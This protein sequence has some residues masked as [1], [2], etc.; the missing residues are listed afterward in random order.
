MTVQ[1]DPNFIEYIG[2]GAQLTFAF[3]FRVD[4]VAWVSLS[5]VL[6]LLDITLNVD[7]DLNPGGVVSYNIAPPNL[8]SIRILRITPNNQELN[9]T[10]YDPFDSESHESALDRLTMQIQ[11]AGQ[12]FVDLVAPGTVANSSLRYDPTTPPGY[13]EFGPGVDEYFF[14]A[15]DGL[16][17]QVMITDGAGQVFFANAGGGGGG[18]QISGAPTNNQ[19]AVWVNPT[20]IEG[21]SELTYEDGIFELTYAG[22]GTSINLNANN[23]NAIIALDGEEAGFGRPQ[24]FFTSSDVGNGGVLFD[25]SANLGLFD[26]WQ[27]N[28]SGTVLQNRWLSFQRN[29]SAN[30]FFNGVQ[31]LRT[32]NSVG[33]DVGMG[34]EVLRTNGAFEPVGMNVLPLRVQN[35]DLIFGLSTVGEMIIH[36]EVPSRTYS[37][38]DIPGTKVGS[39]WAVINDAG[40]GDILFQAG[41][42]C[43]ITYWNGTG[44]T[45]SLVAG[46]V[47]AGEGQFTVYKR[48]DFEYYLTGPNLT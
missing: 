44:W 22:V 16:P 39:M 47:I 11:D 46:F 21:E 48:T 32:S 15:V 28:T 8:Q 23:G 45:T 14:P 30:F 34:A 37:L 9:Y 29:G 19:L 38:V 33:N 41:P 18:A 31:S 12:A 4:D 27:T 36:D 5:Y 10:R 24:L 13:R 7:Q 3:S 20:D 17:G 25:L 40:A 6:N 43:V 35:A 1:D 42:G 26:F 2:D